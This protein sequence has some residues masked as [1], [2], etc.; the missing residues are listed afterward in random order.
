MRLDKKYYDGWIFPANLYHSYSTDIKWND[1]KFSLKYISK[2]SGSAKL[3]TSASQA[4]SL[5]R[6]LTKKFTKLLNRRGIVRIGDHRYF[7]DCLLA[8]EPG[9]IYWYESVPIGD[10]K[11]CRLRQNVSTFDLPSCVNT[12]NIVGSVIACDQYIQY[13]VQVSVRRL[14]II[15]KT[16]VERSKR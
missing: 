15:P 16:Y 2:F 9:S 1:G 5:Q 12:P 10:K 6:S 4:M 11:V 14:C 8:I 7:L 3:V 13:S